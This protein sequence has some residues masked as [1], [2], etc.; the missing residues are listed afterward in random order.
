MSEEIKNNK[1][2]PAT[3]GIVVELRNEMISRFNGVDARFEQLEAKVDARFH[4]L[5]I[6]IEEQNAKNDFVLDG[7]SF[8]HKAQ[9]RI[10]GR[11]DEIERW[12]K[13]LRN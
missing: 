5:K 11:Q 6:L 9:E 2:I 4:E 8:L 13:G 12:L 10:E 1:G 3:L 7:L